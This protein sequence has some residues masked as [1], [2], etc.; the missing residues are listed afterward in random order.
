MRKIFTFFLALAASVGT[1]TAALPQGALKGLFTI[2]AQ[3]DKIA[4]SQ[5]NLQYVGTW[6]FATNQWDYFGTSQSDDHRDLFGWGTGNNPNKVIA[7]YGE[8]DTFVDWGTNAITNGGNTANLWRTPTKDEWEYLFYTRENAATLFGL[9][10]V[11]GV[12]GLII[13]PDS[14][15]LPDGAT[16]TPSTTQGMEDKGGYY[17]D[18]SKGHFTDNTY[19]TETWAVMES[20]GAVFFPATGYREGTD[21]TLV[22]KYGYCWSATP[23]ETN[24]AYNLLFLLSS[25][26]PPYYNYQFRGLPVRLIHD[27][28]PAVGDTIIAENEGNTLIYTVTALAPNKVKLLKNG[29][30]LANNKM[31]IPSSVE[32]LGQNFAVDEIED[33][34]R[35]PGAETITLP[36]SL[37][38]LISFWNFRAVDLKAFEVE[39]GS[40]LYTAVDGVLYSADKKTLYRCPEKNEFDGTFASEITSFSNRAFIYCTGL[41]EVT[42]PNTISYL[43]DNLFNSSSLQK[44]T[45]PASVT[46]F[47]NGVFASCSQLAEV[48]FEDV[49]NLN[50][51]WDAFENSKILKDQG[52]GLQRI[53][54]LAV[55]WKGAYPETLEIP[56][57]IVNVAYNF[58]GNASSSTYGDLKKIVFPSTLKRINAKAFADNTAQKMANLETIV[59]KAQTVPISTDYLNL[60]HDGTLTLIVPCGRGAGYEG[61]HWATGHSIDVIEEALVYD[62]QA[63]A[64]EGGSI[65]LDTTDCNQVTLTATADNAHYTFDHW[66]NGATTPQITITVNRDTNLVASFRQ[67]ILVGDTLR[68]AY[69]GNNLYYKILYKNPTYKTVGVVND[70]TP[71]TYWTESNEPEGALVI[72][73][74]IEDW[75]GTKYAVTDIYQYAFRDCQKITSID[76]SENK[77][78][79]TVGRYSFGGCTAATSVTLSDNIKEIMDYAF[80]QMPLTSIDL[81]NVENLGQ[82]VFMGGSNIETVHINKAL[83]SI[84]DQTGLFEHAKTITCDAENTKYVVIDNALYDK[85]L[86]KLISLPLGLTDVEIHI[87]ATVSSMLYES[88]MGFEGTL[89]INSEITANWPSSSGSAFNSPKGDVFVGCHLLDFYTTGRYEGLSGDFGNIKSLNDTLLYSFSVSA[90]EHGSVQFISHGQCNVRE[91]SAFPDEHYEFVQWSNGSTENPLDITVVGDTAISASFRAIQYDITFVD[92]LTDEVIEVKQGTFGSAVEAPTAPTHTGYLFTGWDNDDYLNIPG[93]VTVTALYEI[94]TTGFEQIEQSQMGNDKFIKDGQLFIRRNGELFNAQGARVK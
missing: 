59:C 70:G 5:G 89:F 86:T 85:E 32:Y 8:Y 2:N 10:S 90:G 60:P 63:S 91:I 13:L 56:E 55:K 34:A 18:D 30:T 46:S 16:F 26:Y 1:M 54:A 88:M 7:E 3:G 69:K 72:P 77:N 9:G 76:L 45:I 44:V 92:G 38:K 65:A 84:P 41:T 19:T 27:V 23:A 37:T 81:K 15:K 6:Q 87:P 75:Q 74:S 20:A 68:Y 53:G 29:H 24:K 11:N 49:S 31:V 47:A 83:K 79:T 67:N 82:W 22:G 73:D 61:T 50:V 25:L 51:S 62:I 4:F 94:D 58:Y 64:E 14:W 66:S 21:V 78:I 33:N 40:T 35:F 12:N 17:N 52:D 71:E 39:E 43:N 80:R 42:I 36:A 57:G 28:V 93:S 48:N